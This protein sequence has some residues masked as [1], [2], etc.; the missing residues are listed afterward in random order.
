MDRIERFLED[1]SGA[2]LVEWAVVTV[3]VLLATLGVL[4]VIVKEGL[5]RFFDGVM[6][7]LGLHRVG[8]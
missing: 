7:D 8:M 2:E 5:P 6:E 3:I 4:T 1:E